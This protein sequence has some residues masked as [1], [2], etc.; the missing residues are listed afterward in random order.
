MFD[1]YP[2]GL[3]RDRTLKHPE[4]AQQEIQFDASYSPIA[5]LALDLAKEWNSPTDLPTHGYYLFPR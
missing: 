4:K 1:K 3:P 5:Q 2:Y